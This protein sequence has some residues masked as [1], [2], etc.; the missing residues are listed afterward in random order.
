MEMK[1]LIYVNWI[2]E[3][4]VPVG[5]FS[6]SAR[7]YFYSA[8]SRANT[9][10]LDVQRELPTDAYF[11]R[12]NKQE[13]ILYHQIETDFFSENID[14]HFIVDFFNPNAV[15]GHADKH[16]EVLSALTRSFNDLN[17]EFDLLDEDKKKKQEL[18]Q[19]AIEECARRGWVYSRNFLTHDLYQRRYARWRRP[20]LK[21]MFM[22]ARR[23]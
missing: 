4:I 6:P 18:R 7:E 3:C 15:E 11:L 13:I 9:L 12:G 16:S 10:A 5:D 19:G 21:A 23:V 1:S 22:K 2:S 8:T 20:V 17:A 14:Q